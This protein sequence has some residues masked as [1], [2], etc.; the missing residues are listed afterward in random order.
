M[1]NKYSQKPYDSVT[2]SITD[3]IKASSKRAIQKTAEATGDLIANEIADS[4]T[5]I[6]KSPNE[7]D[8]VKLRS[9]SDDNEIEV[10][11]ERYTSREKKETT[12]WWITISIII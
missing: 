9:K 1:G 11:K 3:S 8:S 6:S 2:K 7:L 12:Y 5:S 10:S 4:I